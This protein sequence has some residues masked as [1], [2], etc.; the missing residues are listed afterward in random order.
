MEVY[1]LKLF[2]YV[3]LAMGYQNT[4]WKLIN[5]DIKKERISIFL[6]KIVLLFGDFALGCG[7]AT[8]YP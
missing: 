6:V 2:C 7:P 5:L 8:D 3:I 1:F 4:A